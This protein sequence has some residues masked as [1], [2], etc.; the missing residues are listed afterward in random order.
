MIRKLTVA[1]L[2][3]ICF[4]APAAAQDEYTS[5][6]VKVAD[7]NLSRPRDVRRLDLRI[8]RAAETVCQPE[9]RLDLHAVNGITQCKRES[10]AASHHTLRAP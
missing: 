8:A 6:A 9:T 7:L 1:A 3:A 5:I 4:V 2:A 10:V